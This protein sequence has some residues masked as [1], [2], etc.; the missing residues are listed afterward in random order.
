MFHQ[1]YLKKSLRSQIS[2]TVLYLSHIFLHF[3]NVIHLYF[4][5]L[6]TNFHSFFFW[7]GKLIFRKTY[8][9]GCVDILSTQCLIG[10]QRIETTIRGS[11]VSVTVYGRLYGLTLG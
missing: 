8:D 6:F 4:C 11:S 9:H 2:I 10:N 1:L 5:Y 3:R 7:G